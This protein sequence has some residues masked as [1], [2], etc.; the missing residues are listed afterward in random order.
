VARDD[1]RPPTAAAEP[2]ICAHQLAVPDC[3][4][5]A[6]PCAAAGAA[7]TE[8]A[9]RPQARYQTVGAEPRGEHEP[10]FAEERDTVTSFQ[11]G[12]RATSDSR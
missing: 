11:T 1:R 5:L 12:G 7:G 10:E 3:L 8:R 2:W 6:L 9:T 4:G